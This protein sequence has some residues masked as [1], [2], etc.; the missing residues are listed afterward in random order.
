M[1]CRRH[2]RHTLGVCPSHSARSPRSQPTRAACDARAA[3]SLPARGPIP[4]TYISLYGRRAHSSCCPNS[5]C[6]SC[7]QVGGRCVLAA[8]LTR[9]LTRHLRVC[10]GCCTYV[11]WLPHLP[12]RMLVTCNGFVAQTCVLSHVRASPAAAGAC[13]GTP[14]LHPP[15]GGGAKRL[16]D[17]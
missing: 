17:S 15:Q 14:S 11:C 12:A 13:R 1:T 5:C 16:P 2:G 7:S 8:A 4:Q 10:A 6:N 9:S 3:A